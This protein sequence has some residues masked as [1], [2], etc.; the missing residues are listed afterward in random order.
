LTYHKQTTF[1]REVIVNI[2]Q[3]AQ[4]STYVRCFSC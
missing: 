4:E 3:Q 1:C 2:L